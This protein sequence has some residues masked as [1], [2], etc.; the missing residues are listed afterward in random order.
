VSWTGEIFSDPRVQSLKLGRARS[1]DDLGEEFGK[2]T[3]LAYGIMEMV[4]GAGRVR[5][6]CRDEGMA[7]VEIK[8][9]HYLRGEEDWD[10]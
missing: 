2:G 10:S 5:I 3:G 4:G 1:L 6:R 9:C 7:G 8:F